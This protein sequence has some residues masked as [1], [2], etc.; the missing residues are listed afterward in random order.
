V[1]RDGSLSGD[2]PHQVRPDAVEEVG[3]VI[4]DSD[5][6]VDGDKD[7][8]SS[9]RCIPGSGTVWAFCLASGGL[10]GVIWVSFERRAPLRTPLGS[11]RAP[12]GPWALPAPVWGPRVASAFSKPTLILGST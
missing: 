3:D 7:G 12:F 8:A 5:N 1:V 4:D 6:N 10:S 2:A 11:L 9:D